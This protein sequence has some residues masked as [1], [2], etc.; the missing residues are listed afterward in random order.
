MVLKLSVY[1]WTDRLLE[2][3]SL[4][5]SCLSEAK[6]MRMFLDI[7]QCHEGTQGIIVDAVFFNTSK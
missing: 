3:I 5:L 2:I 4:S 7:T 6:V 1:F